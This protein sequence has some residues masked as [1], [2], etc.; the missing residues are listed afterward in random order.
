[1]N[2]FQLLDMSITSEM[3]R[4]A[5]TVWTGLRVAKE[6]DEDKLMVV[7]LPDSGT[8]HLSKLYNDDWMKEKGFL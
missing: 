6:L 5:V 8:R 4:S 3:V 7:I 1:M 2:F